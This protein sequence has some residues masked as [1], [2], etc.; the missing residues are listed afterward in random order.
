MSAQGHF[1]L[2]TETAVFLGSLGSTQLSAPWS[3]ADF[4]P[5]VITLY[6]VFLVFSTFMELVGYIVI[7]NSLFGLFSSGHVT[8]FSNE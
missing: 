6:L 3:N 2:P 4:P 7:T 8:I 1:L 5:L